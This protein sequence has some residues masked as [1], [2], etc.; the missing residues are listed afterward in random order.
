[1]KCIVDDHCGG[2][3]IIPKSHQ[4]EVKAAIDSVMVKPARG[5]A[6]GIRD[7]LVTSLQTSGWS[8]K[9]RMSKEFGISISS[10][11]ETTGLCMQT[12][13]NMARMYADWLK[14]QQLYV[15]GKI[16]C[17]VMIVP[18]KPTAKL[19]GQNIVHASRLVQELAFFNKVIHIPLIIF[20]FE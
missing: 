8:A 14:L 6:E 7:A 3:T 10:M 11:K 1:M 9:T 16:T 2:L 20:S 19:L 18:S 12:G 13:G 15:T 4:V 5:A 17:G